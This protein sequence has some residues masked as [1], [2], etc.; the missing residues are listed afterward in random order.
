MMTPE[1][2]KKR[3]EA[4]E[5]LPTADRQFAALED[6]ADSLLMLRQTVFQLEVQMKQIAANIDDKQW[7]GQR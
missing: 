5:K 1:Q 7:R 6:I 3:R 2:W 4:R